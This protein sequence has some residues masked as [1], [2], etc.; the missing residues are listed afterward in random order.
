MKQPTGKDYR[1]LV[2][3]RG[4]QPDGSLL[5]VAEPGETCERVDPK[6]LGWLAEQG[7]ITPVTAKEIA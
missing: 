5:I 7:Y 4:K 1:A 6:S 2:T 3:I